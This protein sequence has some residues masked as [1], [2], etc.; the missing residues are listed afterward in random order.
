MD[1]QAGYEKGITTLAAVL[2]GGNLVNTYPGIVGSL[3]AQSFEG[4]VIDNDM[5][6]MAL[7]VLRG[8]EVT[9]ETLAV[10]G[11]ERAVSGEGHFLGQPQ[12]LALMQSE[13]LYPEVG[14]RRT[15]NEWEASGRKNVYELAHEE[16]KAILGSHYPEYLA[17]NV[18][19]AIRD[20]FP[21]KLAPEDMRPGSGRWED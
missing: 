21:I 1:A 13:Y 4:M 15:P 19:A 6:G 14:D 9:D 7:R 5:M 11:I 3:M 18:D 2:A 10:E 20:Q 8:I 16:V 12:T 17:P